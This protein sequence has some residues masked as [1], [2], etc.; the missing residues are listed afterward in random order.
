MKRFACFALILTACA[1]TT[2][3][4]AMDHAQFEGFAVGPVREAALLVVEEV[5]HPRSVIRITNEGGVRTEGWIG[6]CGEQVACPTWSGHSGGGSAGSPWTTIQVRFRDAKAGTVVEV[7]IE[8]EDCDPDV[9]CQPELLAST[10]RLERQI[11]D[12]IRARLEI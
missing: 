11:L 4:G 7:E 10:G 8:Y 3:T 12:G 1:S 6:V 2:R 5:A 9:A